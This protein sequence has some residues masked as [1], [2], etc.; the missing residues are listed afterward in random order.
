MKAHRLKALYH[1]P[2]KRPSKYWEKFA[3]AEVEQQR[4][5]LFNKKIY[6]KIADLQYLC[7]IYTITLTVSCNFMDIISDNIQLQ[8]H[9]LKIIKQDYPMLNHEIL[10]IEINFYNS[11]Y[12]Q[13]IS[14]FCFISKRVVKFTP[15]IYLHA[16]K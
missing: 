13:I 14:W 4:Y 11:I 6:S 1:E 10:D 8:L 7:Q 15:Q 9:V 3:K 2:I 12:N 16:M 5:S